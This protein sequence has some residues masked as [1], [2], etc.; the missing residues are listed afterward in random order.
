MRITQLANFYSATSGGLRVAV[1]RLATG[2][3]CAGHDVALIVP[4][5]RTEAVDAGWTIKAPALPNGSGYRVIVSRRSV[6]RALAATSP[7]LVECH[8]RLLASWVAPWCRR[9]RIP[10]VTFSHERLDAILAQFAGWLPLPIRTAIA[11]RCA[12]RLIGTT[13]RLIVCSR[14]AAAEYG[15]DAKVR[16]VSLGV[17]LERFRP[18]EKRVGDR[19]H[20][21]C[22]SRLSTEKRPDIAIDCVRE[23]VRRGHDIDLVVVGTGP[24]RAGLRERAAGL[25]IRFTGFLPP[26]DVAVLLAGADIALAPGPAETFGLGALEALACGTPIV[27]VLGAGPSEFVRDAPSAGRSVELDPLAFAGA[28]ESLLEVSREDRQLAARHVAGEYDWDRT[29]AAM[30]AVHA[31]LGGRP[32]VRL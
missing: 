17:D 16:M 15:D 9:R 12:H 11:A 13:D 2:Y 1:D 32:A 25:P 22:V 7:E 19:L 14:F 29:V 4:A 21:I 6:L 30:L 20:L 24:R 3:R 18:M 23:L 26:P 27:A 10:V 31:E 5:G 28:V 8:D